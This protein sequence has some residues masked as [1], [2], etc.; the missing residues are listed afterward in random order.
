MIERTLGLA[1]TSRTYV[2]LGGLVDNLSEIGV[3]L[4]RSVP[5]LAPLIG[6]HDTP[7]F[8]PP[9]LDATTRLQE[10]LAALVDWVAHLAGDTRRLVLVEDVHWSDPTTLAL[11]AAWRRRPRGVSSVWSPPERSPPC[12]W[13]RHAVRVPSVG[14]RRPSP[15]RLSTTSPARPPARAGTERRSSSGP[16]ASRC[17]SRS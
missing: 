11:W 1:R 13:L 12:P 14:S 8:A 4:E 15:A 5:L 2:R 16:R 6:V 10:T 17:S 3:D 9:T 7:G